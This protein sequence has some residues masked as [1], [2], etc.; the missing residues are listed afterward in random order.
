MIQSSMSFF[1]VVLVQPIFNVLAIIYGLIP[2]HDFGVALIVFTIIVRLA[3]W[4]LIKKQLHQ[5]KIMRQL[6]P[7]LTKIKQRA[8]GNKQLEGT[9]M[10]ELYK[11]RGVSPFSSIGTLLLQLPI[12]IALFAVVRLITENHTNIA[13][14]T[15]DFLEQLPGIKEAIAGSLHTS[16]LGLVDLTQH[17]TA[18][19]KGTYWPLMLMA[20]VAGVLQYIQS[21]QLLPQPKEKRKLRDIL[22]DQ[23]SGKEV[24]QSE[25]NTLMT[26]KMV[27]L[28][29]II[30]FM[31]STYLEGALVL[32]LLTTSIVAIIQQ[33]SVLDKDETELEKLSEKT[34]IK[35]KQAKVAEVIA[36]AHK[37][38]QAANKRRS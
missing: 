36:P 3:M 32:Y 11:E 7:E 12:F 15:Y 20:V 1:D 24:D 37:G 19:G 6:Q 26:G 9:L 18:P 35:A 33:K 25:V 30:T 8:K 21:K 29:P 38:K 2:G 22:K 31:I 27:W 13:K 4:P 16:F 10:M 28:F 17:A 14:Y 34:K 5:S 23:A